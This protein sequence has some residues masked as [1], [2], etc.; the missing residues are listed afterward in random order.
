MK[1]LINCSDC[2][3]EISIFSK[4]CNQCGSKRPFLGLT[5]KREDLVKL[6][7]S[8]Y[9]DFWNFTSGGGKIKSIRTKDKWFFIIAISFIVGAIILAN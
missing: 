7:F 2:Q 5:Y 9:S 1:K 4:E 3:S 6:G 8:Q